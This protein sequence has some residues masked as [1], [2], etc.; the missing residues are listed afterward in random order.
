MR[1]VIYSNYLTKKWAILHMF[2]NKNELKK[3]C[4]TIWGLPSG[5]KGDVMWHTFSLWY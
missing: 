5:V 2:E 4:S 1:Q 3:K